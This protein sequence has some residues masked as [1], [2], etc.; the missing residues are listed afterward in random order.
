MSA[1]TRLYLARLTSR[2]FGPI[3]TFFARELKRA[4]KTARQ[5]V[6]VTLHNEL[7]SQPPEP[8]KTDS[9][10]DIAIWS[11][12]MRYWAWRTTSKADGV[13]GDV[14]IF[15]RY[16]PPGG[17]TLLERSTA[18]QKG[19]I[20]LVNAK[21]AGKS[22]AK[23]NIIIVHELLHVLG[24]TDKY[25]FATG[26]PIAPDGLAYPPRKPRYPQREAEIM[27]PRIALSASK[28]RD[29]KSLGQVVIGRKTAREINL[30]A[31]AQ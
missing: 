20:G 22:E 23:N 13:P 4:G 12:K 14:S 19:Q 1:S 2:T 11:L 26:Q 15:V 3:E 8:P 5:P 29:P 18:L 30:R 28:W 21:A 9:R 7:K 25:D 16:H 27:A 10:W 31:S 24:A 6:V 17:K